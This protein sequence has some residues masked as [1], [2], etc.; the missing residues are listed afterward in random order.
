MRRDQQRRACD[1]G[2]GD[3]HA[4]NA[5]RAGYGHD[6]VKFSLVKIGRDFQEHRLAAIAFVRTI[7]GVEHARQQIV[8][9][10]R[11]LQIPQARRVGRGNVDREIARHIRKRSDA[12]YVIGAAIKRV[13]VGA[14]VDANNALWASTFAQAV[15]HH[16]VPLAVEAEAVDDRLVLHQPEQARTRIARLGRRRHG[17]DFHKAESKPQQGARHVCAFVKASR[18]ADGIGKPQAKHI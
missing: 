4:V 18:H 8:E 9:R 16:L 17:A 2:V 11:L 12:R 14:D 1:C 5:A 3:D 7:A 13:L 10:R 6:V 15:M